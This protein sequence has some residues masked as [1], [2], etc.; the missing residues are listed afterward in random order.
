MI[1]FIE[2]TYEAGIIT[3]GNGNQVGEAGACQ[4]EGKLCQDQRRKR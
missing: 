2:E 4:P 3:D 1:I